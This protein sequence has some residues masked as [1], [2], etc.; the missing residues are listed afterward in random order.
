M[1]TCNHKYVNAQQCTLEQTDSSAGILLISRRYLIQSPGASWCSVPP[2]EIQD[3]GDTQPGTRGPMPKNWGHYTQHQLCR[4][5]ASYDLKVRKLL[6]GK[7]WIVWISNLPCDIKH[8]FFGVTV[9]SVLPLY[10]PV[11]VGP[12]SLPCGGLWRGATTNC[13]VQYWVST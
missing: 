11:N 1:I 8:R 2:N 7:I 6:N 9:E 5:S 13:C 3:T 10:I 12:W 4:P